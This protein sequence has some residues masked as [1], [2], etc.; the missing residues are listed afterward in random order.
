MFFVSRT[1][2]EVPGAGLRHWNAASFW[3]SPDG[4]TF[5]PDGA[6]VTHI[7]LPTLT[8]QPVRGQ[9]VQTPSIPAA[10]GP[11]RLR[12]GTEDSLQTGM[13]AAFQLGGG[14]PMWVVMDTLCAGVWLQGNIHAQEQGSPAFWVPAL[15]WLHMSRSTAAAH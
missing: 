5:S 4:A 2:Q 12:K 6:P 13:Q 10:L 3:I 8:Q 7:P 15:P 1:L 9:G 11:S 14:C